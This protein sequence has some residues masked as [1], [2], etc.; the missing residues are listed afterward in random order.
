M[1]SPNGE[2]KGEKESE[3]GK[4]L[5]G[6]RCFEKGGYVTESKGELGVENLTV[7]KTEGL[8][9]VARGDRKYG[10]LREKELRKKRRGFWGRLSLQ[11][12]AGEPFGLNRGKKPEIKN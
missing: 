1:G 7:E 5:L 9:K 4:I 11:K 10:S 8:R 3:K 12:I 2:M 6:G